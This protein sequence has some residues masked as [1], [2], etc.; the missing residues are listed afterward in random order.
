MFF[1]LCP[2]NFVLRPT[3]VFK[4]KLVLLEDNRVLVL[5]FINIYSLKP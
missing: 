5:Y 2:T 3:L 4:F 1:V